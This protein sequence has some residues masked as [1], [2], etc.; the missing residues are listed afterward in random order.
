[1]T[2][3]LYA[4]SSTVEDVLSDLLDR[5]WEAQSGRT[6]P[7]GIS[8]TV[9]AGVELVFAES[10]DGIFGAAPDLRQAAASPG[11]LLDRLRDR[12]PTELDPWTWRTLRAVGALRPPQPLLS[13]A[14][15]LQ[16]EAPAPPAPWLEPH[17]VAPAAVERP[18]LS[19]ASRPLA[20]ASACG[21]VLGAPFAVLGA[22]VAT[23][24]AAAGAVL[25]ALAAAAGGVVALRLRRGRD[26]R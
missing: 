22:T 25:G 15:P 16:L 18:V 4:P 12:L 21:A 9:R 23:P 13:A 24:A 1:M 17:T 20:I 26:E 3:D 6:A 5:E 2:L 19:G 7:L 14:A 10:S 8:S 11:E